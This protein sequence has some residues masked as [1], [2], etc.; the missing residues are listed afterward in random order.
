MQC[1]GALVFTDSRASAAT[2]VVARE[3]SPSADLKYDE[4]NGDAD[5]TDYEEHDRAGMHV[6][7]ECLRQYPVDGYD[8]TSGT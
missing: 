6:F 5:D 8:E 1:D 7:D 3:L 4:A 2:D